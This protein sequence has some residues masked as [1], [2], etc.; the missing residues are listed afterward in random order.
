MKTR[1]A[2]LLTLLLVALAACVPAVGSLTA[3]YRAPAGRVLD[4]AAQ[5]GPQLRPSAGFTAFGLESRSAASLTLAASETMGSQVIGALAGQ[6][7]MTVRVFVS[8]TPL[9]QGS[10][11]VTVSAVPADNAAAIRAA[12]QVAARLE[13]RFGS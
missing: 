3:V 8:V 13:Q 6:G 1:A 10:S 2:Q 7:R 12:E 9:A 4:V 5:V 11:Q